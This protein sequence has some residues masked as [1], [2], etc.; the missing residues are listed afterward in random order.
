MLIKNILKIFKKREFI[1]I[2]NKCFDKLFFI[3]DIRN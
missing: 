1:N 3:K 2:K